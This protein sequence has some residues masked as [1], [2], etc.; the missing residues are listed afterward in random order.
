M[1]ATD[2]DRIEYVQL[3]MPADP[4]QLPLLRQQVRRC[5]A[6]LP[7]SPQRQYETVLAVDEA[8][9][10]AVQHAYGPGHTGSIELTIWTESDALCI[11][12]C[13]H[14]HW[15][16]PQSDPDSPRDGLGITLMHRL[17]DAVFIEHGTRGTR[18][19]L[20]YPINTTAHDRSSRLQRYSRTHRRRH[21]SPTQ[22][23]GPTS[24]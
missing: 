8:A 9:A 2:H 16:Q 14:G 13:D 22:R 1:T 12:V 5:V 10:N 6:G 23:P 3:T 24:A 11:Q 4:A 21:R 19:L 15:R 17:V 20:R 7:I 18:V